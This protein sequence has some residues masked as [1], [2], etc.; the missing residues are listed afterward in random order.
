M[1]KKYIINGSLGV[2]LFTSGVF[3]GGYIFKKLLILGL[4]SVKPLM[5]K[6]IVD[7]YGIAE[8]EGFTEE[9]LQNYI[10]TEVDFIKIVMRERHKGLEM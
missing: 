1:M 3:V 10:A 7:A 4:E 6:A 8:R 5:A 9:E 2:V